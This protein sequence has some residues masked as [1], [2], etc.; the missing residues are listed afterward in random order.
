MCVFE[1][2]TKDCGRAE[3]R[4]HAALA[5][6]RT[7]KWGQEFFEVDLSLAIEVIERECY[8]TDS[9][10]PV[11][12]NLQREATLGDFKPAKPTSHDSASNTHT[13]RARYPST[14]DSTLLSSERMDSA[15]SKRGVRWFT[16]L[17]VVWGL[18]A[19]VRALSKT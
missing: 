5:R 9:T 1:S 13:S 15:T 4:V 3:R 17:L 2:Q 14:R 8:S 6:H 19:I 16:V 18:V 10:Q 11:S 7:G 12:A